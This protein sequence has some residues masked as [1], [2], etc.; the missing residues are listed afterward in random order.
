MPFHQS[1]TLHHPLET[2][3]SPTNQTA[4][5]N[6]TASQ[7]EQTTAAAPR[8]RTMFTGYKSIDKLVHTVIDYV[9]RDYID[10]WYSLVSDD[11][12]FNDVRTRSSIEESVH[13][14]CARIKHTAWVPLI[15]TKLA[16]DLA[17]HT[18][19]YRLAGQAVAGGG[20]GQTAQQQQQQQPQ[21]QQSPQK[22]AAGRKTD[23]LLDAPGFSS[24]ESLRHRRN[25]SDTDLKASASFGAQ[26]NVAN[27]KFYTDAQQHQ[28]NPQPQTHSPSDEQTPFGDNENR[29]TAAFFDIDDKWRDE[30]MDDRKLDEYLQHA[31]ETVLYFCIPDADFACQ[32]LRQF[33][34]AIVTH[35]VCR[36]L[37][38]LLADPDFINLQ[39]ARFVPRESINSEYFVK[40]TRQCTDMAEL[41]ACRQFVV[42]E[43]DAKFRETGTTTSED[44]NSLKYTQKLI[45]MRLSYLQSSKVQSVSSSVHLTANA[46][47]L[48][49]DRHASQV[50]TTDIQMPLLTLE[51]LLNK[52]LAL[53]YYLDYLSTLNFQKYVIFYLTA[54]EWKN[55]AIHDLQS[56]TANGS[57]DEILAGLREKASALHREYL[58]SGS[59]N[60]LQIDRGL[61]EALHIKTTNL[62]IV[63]EPTWFD[64]ICKFVYEKLK[65]EE[66]FLAQFYQ[67]ASYRKLLLELEFCSAAPNAHGGLDF[68]GSGYNCD[69]SS[70]D[71]NSAELPFDE[72][73][74][75][76]LSESD[77]E[78][79][80][81]NVLHV[82]AASAAVG[83]SFKHSRSHSDCTGVQF[84]DPL[85]S[86]PA[87]RSEYPPRAHSP[88]HF[89]GG[90]SSGIAQKPQRVHAHII[91]TAI[92]CDGKYAVYAIEVSVMMDT[93]SSADAAAADQNHQHYDRVRSW[94]VYRRYSK[95]LE[96]KKLLC[97]R[98]VTIARIPFPAK[99]TFQNT[100]R[101]VL[102]HRM[103]VLNE[104]LRTVC[105]RAEDNAEI[106]AVVC[107]FLEPDPNDRRM[108]SGVVIKTI[109]T[110]IVNPIKSGMRTIKNMPDTLV[111]GIAK[112]L[113]GRGP[114]K[115]SSFLDVMPAMEVSNVSVLSNARSGRLCFSFAEVAERKSMCLR[116]MKR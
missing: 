72:D 44:M 116:D 114:M 20:G 34:S 11:P 103:V 32:P 63:P 28:H 10:S 29:L 55:T 39:L 61:I 4:S 104:F 49:S 58:T 19:I 25:K 5:D 85:R 15:T 27:S 54:I 107:A 82:D 62:L 64:S 6:V 115:Q 99:K 66:I 59:S 1:K 26:R 43:M 108:H 56:N 92:L 95:F 96:L 70:G 47:A 9:M 3:R 69:T 97:K 13:N 75:D 93:P 111:G 17:T 12:E 112:I 2:N 102:E 81:H 88:L 89:H 16:D 110:T 35:V 37:L 106:R 86:V 38:D 46:A 42:R 73:D 91:N 77:E 94:H 74:E 79:A 50:G 87:T 105:Q 80:T 40:L 113:L 100:D 109:E 60:C 65:N 41:R 90:G 71:S 68:A 45:D 8:S 31:A 83:S 23:A 22:R 7:S 48:T 18:R 24:N 84:S 21:T 76:E 98:S 67:S 78:T 52:E 51:E 53:S 36:P 14:V 57:R 30:C 101:A 33:L